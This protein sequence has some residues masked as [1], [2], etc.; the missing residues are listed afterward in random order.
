MLYVPKVGCIFSRVRGGQRAAALP[1]SLGYLCMSPLVE[2]IQTRSGVKGEEDN[3][4]SPLDPGP[5]RPCRAHGSIHVEG[6]REP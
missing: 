3:I 2:S 5:A 1:T 6:C 4:R